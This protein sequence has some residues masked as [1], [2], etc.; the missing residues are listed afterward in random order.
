MSVA[1]E[2]MGDRLYQLAL[3][4]LQLFKDAQDILDIYN[5]NEIVDMVTYFDDHRTIWGSDMKRYELSA[6]M[7]LVEQFKKM[8]NNEAVTQALYSATIAQFKRIGS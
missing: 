5:Q 6:A 3:D 8:I 2:A 1:T 4:C 7:V